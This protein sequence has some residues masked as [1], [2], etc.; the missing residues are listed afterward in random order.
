MADDVTDNPPSPFIVQWA[1][2]VASS[3]PPP[4][5][6]LDVAMGRGRHARALA[7]IGYHVFGV[8]LRMDAVTSATEAARATGLIVRGW[9]ADLTMTVLPRGHF[10]LIVVSRYLERDLFESI[11]EALTP[12]GVVIYETFTINQRAHGRGPTSPDH[13]LEQ[14]EL[15]ARFNGFEILFDEE[16]SSP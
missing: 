8:D 14:G 10:D 3:L 2:R 12:G 11:R 16:T 6:A 1:M 7:A 13:L 5:R 9:C 4:G 15:R